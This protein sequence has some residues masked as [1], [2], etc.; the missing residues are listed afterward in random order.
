MFEINSRAI[1]RTAS[2]HASGR[3]GFLKGALAAGAVLVVGVSPRGVVAADASATMDSDMLNPFVSIDADGLVTVYSK[4]TDIGQGTAHGLTTL[5]CEE[6]DAD[7]AQVQAE[8]SAAH[9]VVYKNSLFGAQVTGGST[10]M[11]DSWTQ[12][13]KAGATARAMLVAAA[14]RIWG[15][16]ESE[17]TVEAGRISHQ[18]SRRSGS[19]RDF[20]AAATKE[21][22][23]ETVTLKAPRDWK[24]IGTHRPR[25][26]VVLKSSGSVDAFGMD[27]QLADMLVAST[28]RPPRWGAKLAS[29]D[30][31]EALAVPGVVDVLQ[32]PE[33]VVVLGRATWPTIKAK[34]LVRTEWDF[35]EA[36]NRGTEGLLA[37]YRALAESEGM[38]AKRAGDAPGQIAGVEKAVAR[39]YVFPYL[40]QAP[41]E[42]LNVTIQWDGDSCT[43]WGS[44]QGPTLDQNF[45]AGALGIDPSKVRIIR[46]WGGGSFG[47]RVTYDCHL[48]V[49]AANIAKA[50]RNKS[51]GQQPIKLFYTREDDLRGG[52]YRPMYV[53]RARGTVSP[54]GLIS[55]WHHRVVGQSILS[56]T[57]FADNYVKDGIDA[58]SVEGLVD[59]GYRVENH[60]VE[61]HSPESKVTTLWWRAVGHSHTAYAKETF[62]DALAKEAGV[63][64][65]SFRL[66]HLTGP[67]N[68][69]EAAVVRLAAEK[70]RWGNPAPQGRFRGFA[71]HYSF[72]S[73]VAHVAEISLNEDGLVKIH[74]VTSAVD[75]GTPINPDNIVAQVEGGLG[76]GLGHVLR[77]QITM[78]E[79]AVDQD[80]FYGEYEPLRISD[81]P[82]VD[83]HI[84]PSTEAPTGI[85]EPGLPPIGPA[86]ANAVF[87]ATGEH[88][89][90]L[91]FSGDDLI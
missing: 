80:N 76:Y 71:V 42:P 47:R 70:A 11:A 89:T 81:M 83:V 1:A 14:S 82:E 54:D 41:L 57:I 58:T 73:Y 38:V 32:I 62:M 8:F 51:G 79:G 85:G 52:Y 39:D 88:P 78:T 55:A 9:P 31:A 66:R 33:G 53:H 86:V 37:E 34:A 29:F 6:L 87:S 12:Y 64:P 45:V 59:M 30:A 84:V 44:L 50:W 23:P 15:V 5:L 63:D 72:A 61:L 36:D 56:G 69:R 24:L 18:A 27:V 3:R 60:R 40:A 75:C 28:I 17:I 2:S 10:A 35:T 43:L 7:P 91:P 22:A 48:T 25:V 26:D 21:Q 49:E 67:E 65:V 20:V 90:E 77:N 68:A 74:K 16:P 19:F 46:K 13:R 4:H